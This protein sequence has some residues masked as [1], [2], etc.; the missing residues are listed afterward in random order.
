MLLAGANRLTGLF[1]R[2]RNIY[3]NVRWSGLHTGNRVLDGPAFSIDTVTLSDRT[4]H[5]PSSFFFVGHF[6]PYEPTR[7]YALRAVTPKPAGYQ[8][9]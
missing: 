1:S 6:I 7:S 5:F 2:S 9:A 8:Q 3:L 4:S